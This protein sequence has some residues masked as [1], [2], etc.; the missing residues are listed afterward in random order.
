MP[1]QRRLG[2]GDN[3]IR[4]VGALAV[5]LLFAWT[6]TSPSPVQT[7]PNPSIGF[8]LA[9]QV[10]HGGMRDLAIHD[11]FVLVG[12]IGGLVVVDPSTE[13][14][15][16]VFGRL[17]IGTRTGV[18]LG[19]P[20]GVNAVVSRGRHAFLSTD[21]GRALVADLADPRNPRQV[22]SFE[23]PDEGFDPIALKLQGDVAYL[24]TRSQELH[25]YDVSE[26]ER[27]Q[28]LGSTVLVGGAPVVDLDVAGGYAYVSAQSALLVVDVSNSAAPVQLRSIER[29]REASWHGLLLEGDLG[30]A[31]GL[32]GGLVVLDLS[33]PAEPRT[34]TRLDLPVINNQAGRVYEPVRLGRYLLMPADERGLV[35]IDVSDPLAPV[36]V[37]TL[38]LPGRRAWRA[39]ADS[40]RALVVDTGF[41]LHVIGAEEPSSP[42]LLRSLERPGMTAVHVQGAVAFALSVHGRLLVYDIDDVYTPRKLAHLVLSDAA[43]AVEMQVV[44]DRAYVLMVD[45]D[46]GPQPVAYLQVVNLSQPDRPEIGRRFTASTNYETISATC[47]DRLFLAGENGAAA[48]RLDG[49]GGLELLATW[50]ESS[51][52]IRELSCVEGWL[53]AIAS[54]EEP[55][56]LQ[57]IAFDARSSGSLEPVSRQPLTDLRSPGPLLARGASLVVGSTEGIALYDISAP[58][59]P[60]RSATALD[61]SFRLRFT[62]AMA[63]QDSLL[64]VAGNSSPGL[65]AVD[66]NDPEAPEARGYYPELISANDVD[67]EGARLVIGSSLGGIATFELSGVALPS[68]EPTPKSTATPTPTATAG[69]RVLLPLLVT[70]R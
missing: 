53:Y 10:D 29:S 65:A 39:V 27:P 43:L 60:Q 52:T 64:F 67:A 49:S 1:H 30:F 46:S 42:L 56:G 3:R 47:G 14:A 40:G 36:L 63:H 18:D 41:G 59:R 66:L 23:A 57:L 58:E 70:R 26:P 54:P 15:P 21:D 68:P 6:A 55:E 31:G 33:D 35:S 50:I 44:H 25:L 32:S 69:G 28:L 48:Y 17:D 62:R 22:G 7:Q 5:L 8:R 61:E 51:A 19:R 4:S 37:N 16:V 34:L 2:R 24:V 20:A 45:R 11:D 13:P 9:A 12:Q 38:P